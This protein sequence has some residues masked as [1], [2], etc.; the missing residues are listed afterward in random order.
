MRIVN[1]T[2]IHKDQSSIPIKDKIGSSDYVLPFLSKMAITGHL[3]ATVRTIQKLITS[4]QR[5]RQEKENTVVGFLLPFSLSIS[6][7][8]LS[9]DPHYL[10]LTSL[11]ARGEAGAKLM[12]DR[13]SASHAVYIQSQD[14]HK[15][16]LAENKH[17]KQ[18]PLNM[19]IHLGWT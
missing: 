1:G 11:D 14:A 10:R 6:Q 18:L 2:C 16:R 17:L 19:G 7:T 9:Q 3:I 4:E 5:G 12:W 15:I 8:W 13:L